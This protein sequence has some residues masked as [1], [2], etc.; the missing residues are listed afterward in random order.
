MIS[1]GFWCHATNV[2][3]SW[4]RFVFISIILLE[5]ISLNFIPLYLLQSEH[6]MQNANLRALFS[7]LYFY[8][9]QKSKYL[10]KSIIGTYI[11]C[12]HPFQ[13][14]QKKLPC[15]FP[16]IVLY[17]GRQQ[18]RPL[19]DEGCDYRAQRRST[20]VKS[21]SNRSSSSKAVNPLRICNEVF[22]E[23]KEEEGTWLSPLMQRKWVLWTMLAQFIFDL[24]YTT[25]YYFLMKPMCLVL[26]LDS[27]AGKSSWCS[28][29]KEKGR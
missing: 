3:W 7:A 24:S 22:F 8:L 25:T 26:S 18:K 27:D 15:F 21:R 4:F 14:I 10:K 16:L 29:L 6:G 20:T 1:C 17:R 11:L 5:D 9:D 2:H 23:E 19:P 12:H 13:Q 28:F